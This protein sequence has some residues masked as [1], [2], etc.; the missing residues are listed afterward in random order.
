MTLH[1]ELALE[2]LANERHQLG[3]FAKHQLIEEPWDEIDWVALGACAELL[4]AGGSDSL[5]ELMRRHMPLEVVRVPHLLAEFYKRKQ[6]S[7]FGTDLAASFH[8]H[9]V[10]FIISK[11]QTVIPYGINFGQGLNNNVHIIQVFDAVE[12]HVPWGEFFAGNALSDSG[13]VLAF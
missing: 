10:N 3:H 13:G 5:A 9:L 1:S 7:L 4:L 12:V 6:N 11:L 8:G 2:S